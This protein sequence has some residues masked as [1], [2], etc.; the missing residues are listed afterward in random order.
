MPTDRG[1]GIMFLVQITDTHN[2]AP[3]DLAYGRFDTA[4][5]LR[6]AVEAINN[7][8][9]A[10]DLVL[11][12]GDM[13]HHGSSE[14]YRYFL[15]IVADL[16][17]PLFAVPGNHDNRGR[18][19]EAFKGTD[20]MPD[21]GTFLHYV[22]EDHDVRVICCDSVLE[23][24]VQGGFCS[25]R[26][27]WIDDQLSAASDKPTIVALHHPPFGSGMSG[28]TSNGLVE[29]GSAFA[30]ILRRHSQVVRV[31]AGH[32]HRPF[33]C[34]FRG[35]I[36]YAAPTTCYPF[37]LEMGSEKILSIIDEPPAISVHLWMED[38]GVGE[39]GLVTHTVPI[40][41]WGDPTILLRDGKRV[42]PA[43]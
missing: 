22:I 42:L 21:D 16:K 13:A 40:D 15:E 20:W 41:A 3:G 39:P 43:T 31:I 37:A 11:H 28:S 32:A 33:T 2:E 19:R 35:T 23:G 6:A 8:Q 30:A 26:L 18:F 12:T 7:M 29:G 14:R 17:P 9:P 27:S 10:P 1:T 4:Q 38:T 34:A 24:R 36:G 5:N 25:E